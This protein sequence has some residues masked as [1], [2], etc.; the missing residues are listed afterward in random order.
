MRR[1]GSGRDCTDD[2]V[3]LDVRWLK[4]QGYLGTGWSGMVHW[5]R[6]GERFASIGV[7]AAE[8]HSVTFMR[9]PASDIATAIINQPSMQGRGS[10]ESALSA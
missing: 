7:E 1:Y 5:S 9:L 4:R 2:Y 6:R 10:A 8:G 3:R